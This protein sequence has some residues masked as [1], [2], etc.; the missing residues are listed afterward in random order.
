[1]HAEGFVYRNLV[2]YIPKGS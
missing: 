1:M 2:H